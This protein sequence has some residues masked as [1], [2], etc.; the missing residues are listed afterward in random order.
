MEEAG[1]ISEPNFDFSDFYQ[2][3]FLSDCNIQLVDKDGNI[4][5]KI[6]AHRLVLANSSDY[7][8]SSFTIQSKESLTSTVD[9]CL[10]NEEERNLFPL[11]I[12]WMYQG[13][14]HISL[15]TFMPLLYMARF[16]G[17]IKLE[18]EMKQYLKENISSEYILPLVNQCYAFGYT[19]ELEFLDQYT[20]KHFSELDI[21]ALSDT[22]DVSVFCRIISKMNL[23]IENRI[24]V[25]N[26]FISSYEPSEDEKEILLNTLMP[27]NKQLKNLVKSYGVT[28]LPQKFLNTCK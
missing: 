21:S 16:F 28:W 24:N 3:D 1:E 22:Y 9:V 7:F 20:I 11:I 17:I 15:E 10:S 14:I 26:Q 25:I 2:D 23:D 6:R 12:C 19:N 13:D 18:Q 4:F 27:I 5:S 8:N